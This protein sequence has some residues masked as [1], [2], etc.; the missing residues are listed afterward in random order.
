M[1]NE[2]RTRAETM[3]H[4][5]RTKAETLERQSKERAVSLEQD[6]TRKYIEILDA[7]SREKWHLEDNIDK[8][9]AFDQEYRTQVITYGQSQLQKLGSA[10]DTPVNLARTQQGLLALRAGL[11]MESG[12]PV[13]S[14]EARGQACAAEMNQ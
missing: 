5:A 3:L 10:S 12:Q 6:A 7:L 1:V 14:L 2:A 4:D 11:A 9:R 8:L 13:S